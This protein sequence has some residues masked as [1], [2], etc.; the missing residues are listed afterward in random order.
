MRRLSPWAWVVFVLFAL[1][2]I[3]FGVFPGTWFE[4]DVERDAQWL[5]TSY[6]AVAVVLTL[7]VAPTAFRC[8]ERWAWLAFWI[9]PFFFVIHGIVFFVVDFV[10]AALGVIALLIA[11]PRPNAASQPPR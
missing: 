9:W 8:G 10:F 3:L 1:L 11:R 4:D 6:A 5:V 7:A 2:A